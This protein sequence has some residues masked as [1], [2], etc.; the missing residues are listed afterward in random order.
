MDSPGLVTKRQRFSTP[1]L[2]GQDL[3]G[4]AEATA[5]DVDTWGE[6]RVHPGPYRA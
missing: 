5:L 2:E 6:A 3:E 4:H 1:A